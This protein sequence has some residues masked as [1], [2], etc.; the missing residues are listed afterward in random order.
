MYSAA[1]VLR[2]IA[3]GFLAL[4]LAVSGSARV[5]HLAEP[6]VAARPQTRTM[7][8]NQVAPHLSSSSQP[9]IT[10]RSPSR[11]Q[12]AWPPFM[13]VDA[14]QYAIC[15]TRTLDRLRLVLRSQL[16]RSFM[17]GFKPPTATLI[18]TAAQSGLSDYVSSSAQQSAP[19][20]TTLERRGEGRNFLAL[21]DVDHAAAEERCLDEAVY[22]EARGE[23]E[24]GQAAV[25][26]VVLNRVESGHYPASICGVV[27]Q[28]R[29][30]RNA[31]QF[32]FAC[33]GNTLRVAEPVSWRTA[34]RIAHEALLGGDYS[35]E[36]GGSTHYI[37]DYAH[38]RWAR[39]L[40]RMDVIGHHIFY[41]AAPAAKPVCMRDTMENAN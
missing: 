28:Q 2:V 13:C 11:G 21:L 16:A 32:S 27:H 26:Q 22:F 18:A 15:S 10:D 25:A 41:Q 34:V 23:P 9:L 31:C 3:E 12:G 40:Q 35:A 24:A 19:N 7:R 4:L 36:V 8:T 29:R 30:R 38:P 5:S 20:T 6:S 39:T 33:R 37:A 14:R 1:D 17:R